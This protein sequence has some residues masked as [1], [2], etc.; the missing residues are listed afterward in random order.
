MPLHDV[1]MAEQVLCEGRAALIAEEMRK[2]LH[3]L[4]IVGQRMGLLVRDHLQPVLDPPQELIGRGR[5]RRA[6]RR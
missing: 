1:E 4:G 5:V 6:P 2:A 3:R